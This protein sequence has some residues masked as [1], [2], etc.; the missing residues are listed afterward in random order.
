MVSPRI[1]RFTKISAFH[2]NLR[3]DSGGGGER[4]RGGGGGGGGGRGR[5]FI[6]RPEIYSFIASP[7][8]D[9]VR[10]FWMP[11]VAT[12]TEP[13]QILCKSS[14]LSPLS[15]FQCLCKIQSNLS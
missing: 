6:D 14:A 8:L 11:S 4:G 10:N 5:G 7:S 15:T 1:G 13:V 9:S 2:F 3:G 12:V